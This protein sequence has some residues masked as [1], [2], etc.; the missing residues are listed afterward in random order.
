MSFYA[1]PAFHIA[2]PRQKFHDNPRTVPVFGTA[3][4]QGNR[5]ESE[6]TNQ[7]VSVLHLSSFLRPR[8]RLAKCVV[9]G[10]LTGFSGIHLPCTC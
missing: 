9:R 2:T 8:R 4:D 1:Q 3:Q 7:A 6:P 5:S 10:C